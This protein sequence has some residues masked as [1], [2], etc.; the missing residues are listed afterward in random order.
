MIKKRFNRNNI[1]TYVAFIVG[2]VIGC[3]FL[4]LSVIYGGENWL[5]LGLEDYDISAMLNIPEYS[6]LFHLLKKRLV[7]LLVFGL[8]CILLGVFGC[9]FFFCGSFGFYYGMVTTNLIIK[10]GISGMFYSIACFYPHYLFY[11]FAIVLYGKWCGKQDKTLKY[12]YANMNWLE[13]IIKFFVIFVILLLSFLWEW[14]V[15][16]TFLNYFFQYLV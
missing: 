5:E 9:S 15:Q 2:V 13:I 10:Y 1:C 11:F 3:V 16:K 6:L 8:L 14:K 12:Y 7:Q 4:L